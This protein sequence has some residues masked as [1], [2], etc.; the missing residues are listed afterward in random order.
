MT[1]STPDHETRLWFNPQKKIIK[2]GK[3]LFL[4]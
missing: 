3:I 1:I 4:Y 2:K